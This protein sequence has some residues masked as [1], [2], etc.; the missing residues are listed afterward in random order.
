M[1]SGVLLAALAGA[2]AAPATM[3]ILATLARAGR[4]A[5]LTRRGGADAASRR[6]G[7]ADHA[8]QR[9]WDADAAAQRRR[10]DDA[11]VLLAR[12]GVRTPHGSSGRSRPRVAYERT[13]SVDNER[14]SRA[15]MR[16]SNDC[17][18]A[19]ATSTVPA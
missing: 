11:R 18:V 2:L 7:D 13:A 8:S 17:A 12:L 6:H 10:G 14:S 1:S 9:R 4:G 3:S 15:R 19:P 5:L 16:C